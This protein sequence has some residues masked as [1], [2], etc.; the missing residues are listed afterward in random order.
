MAVKTGCAENEKFL[1]LS[2]RFHSSSPRAKNIPLPIRPS[3]WLL[4]GIPPQ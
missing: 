3:R 2:I 1:S 4:V